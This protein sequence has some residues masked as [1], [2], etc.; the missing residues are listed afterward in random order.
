MDS[1]GCGC[2][3]AMGT[4]GDSLTWR[5]ETSPGVTGADGRKAAV[6]GG[7]WG[8][9]GLQAASGREEQVQREQAGLS[10]VREEG[11]HSKPSSAF[12][13]TSGQGDTLNE[14]ELCL[15]RRQA[16]HPMLRKGTTLGWGEP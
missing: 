11:K 5:S 12:G 1:E 9:L 4:D 10:G 8:V 3:G 7:D 6:R 13:G 16:Q 15:I 2:L 14:H